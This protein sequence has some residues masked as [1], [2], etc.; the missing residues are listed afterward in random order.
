MDTTSI[1]YG[2]ETRGIVGNK[3]GSD[4]VRVYN[5]EEGEGRTNIYLHKAS[6]SLFEKLFLPLLLFLALFVFLSTRL[7]VPSAL[8]NVAGLGGGEGDGYEKAA[9]AGTTTT[10][11]N[12]TTTTVTT[13]TSTKDT[14]RETEPRTDNNE[15]E[16]EPFNHTNPHLDSWCPYAQCYNSPVC[17]PCNRRFLFIISTGRSGSTTLLKMLNL[18]PNVRISGENNNEMYFAS[19]L[20]DNIR[21]DDK[22]FYNKNFIKKDGRFMHGAMEDGAFRHNAMPIGSMA[23]IMQSIISALNPPDLTTHWTDNKNNNERKKIFHT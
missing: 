4:D 13:I 8:S 15:Y 12:T 10:I 14:E 18:L 22:H 23:C 17:T 3:N 16:Y 5:G 1:D 9:A 7:E 6:R 19:Q 20:I 11:T 2:I 21:K